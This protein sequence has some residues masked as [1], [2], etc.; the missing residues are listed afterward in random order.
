MYL[1]FL[2][3]LHLEQVIFLLLILLALPLGSAS[4]ATLDPSSLALLGSG[5]P[6]SL[7]SAIFATFDQP[8]L[9][10]NMIQAVLL[11]LAQAVLQHLVQSVML[12]L[13]QPVLLNL[14]IQICFLQP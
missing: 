4:S 10:L 5:S 14:Q 3:L 13:T 12:Y 1:N 7:G 6:F 11:H 9:L 2:V 8:V